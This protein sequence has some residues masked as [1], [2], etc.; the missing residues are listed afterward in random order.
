MACVT[1]LFLG[2][3]GAAEGLCGPKAA[4]VPFSGP[5]SYRTDR[6][7]VAIVLPH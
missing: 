3:A 4:K 1:A 7:A 6:C 2:L 5:S